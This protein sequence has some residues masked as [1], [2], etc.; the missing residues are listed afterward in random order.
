MGLS[1]TLLL[2]GIT[3]DSIARRETGKMLQSINT[4]LLP[5]T[6]HP[7]GITVFNWAFKLHVLDKNVSHMTN[8]DMVDV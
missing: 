5:E 3:L 8:K 7:V 4:L 1:T 6:N 2:A